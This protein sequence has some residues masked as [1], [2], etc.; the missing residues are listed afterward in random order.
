MNVGHWELRTLTGDELLSMGDDGGSLRF[1][2]DN[3][4]SLRCSC[5]DTKL[6]SAGDSQTPADHTRLG[7]LVEQQI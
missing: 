6:Q 2:R 7:F 4:L 5:S 1:K 3:I